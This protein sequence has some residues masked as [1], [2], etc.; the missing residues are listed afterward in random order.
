MAKYIK[1][2]KKTDLKID[3][4]HGWDLIS[5]KW[6]IKLQGPI[7]HNNN[8]TEWFEKEESYQKYLSKLH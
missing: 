4:Y 6:F 1:N 8:I 5:K 7:Y 3:I 2:I